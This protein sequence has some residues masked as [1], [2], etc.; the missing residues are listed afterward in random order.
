MLAHRHDNALDEA[1]RRGG[2]VGLPA[3]AA[4]HLLPQEQLFAQHDH[5]V[6]VELGH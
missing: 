1:D 5:V 2:V 6:G 3:L 4:R